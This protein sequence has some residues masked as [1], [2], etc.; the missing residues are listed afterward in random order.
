MTTT[1]QAPRDRASILLPKERIAQLKLLAADE[2]CTA[3]EYL[4]ETIRVKARKK[5]INLPGLVIA[6]F[7]SNLVT[8]YFTEPEDNSKLLF[9]M[10]ELTAAEARHLASELRALL[11]GGQRV[12]PAFE[13]EEQGHVIEVYRQAKGVVL[14]MHENEA[15]GASHK[16]SFTHSVTIDV[17]DWLEAGAR[18]VDG[19]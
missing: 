18:T 5:Q 16:K 4:E 17:I 10:L 2:G 12:R 6:H 14:A 19:I 9:P 11:K 15:A 13:T 1:A 7:K 8:L 3:T